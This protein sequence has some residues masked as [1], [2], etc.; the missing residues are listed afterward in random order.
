MEISFWKSGLQLLTFVIEIGKI[1]IYG[2][3]IAQLSQAV[4]RGATGVHSLTHGSMAYGT[5]QTVPNDT[6]MAPT[7]MLYPQP[8]LPTQP[9][10]HQN[11]HHKRTSTPAEKR[12]MH[13]GNHL[14]GPDCKRTYTSLTHVAL[15]LRSSRDRAAGHV[16]KGGRR[17]C[18]T[19]ELLRPRINHSIEACN[20]RSGGGQQCR[21]EAGGP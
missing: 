3:Q 14:H 19:K 1:P 7:R 9:P 13:K 15:F 16:G 18:G 2:L 21:N 12:R 4:I 17:K 10:L 6:R 8:P 11:W 5:T 20:S